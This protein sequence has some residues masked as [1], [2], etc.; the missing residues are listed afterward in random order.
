VERDRCFVQ[1]N[2]RL[3]GAI[4]FLINCQDVFHLAD[5]LGVQTTEFGR[6]WYIPRI[7]SPPLR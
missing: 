5:V 7:R 6:D 1:A 2:H 4:G 3:G